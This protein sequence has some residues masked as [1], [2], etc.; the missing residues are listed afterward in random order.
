[1][2]RLK[3][4]I[5][6]FLILAVACND[7]ENAADA[8][9]NFETRE[10]MISAQVNGKLIDLQVEKGEIL[11][12]DMVVGMIDTLQYAL[13]LQR[14]LAQKQ[15]VSSRI[16]DIR[17]N[18]S[19]MEAQKSNLER[20]INR[21]RNLL[22]DKAATQQ[23]L[24]DLEGKL[25]VTDKQIQ[26]AQTSMQNIHHELQAMDSQIAI[27]AEQLS[28]CTIINPLQGTVLEKYAETFELIMPG[29]PLYKIADLS[30]MDLKVYVSGGMLP[31]IALGQNVRV[32]IDQDADTNREIQGTVNWI[33]SRAEFTPKTIQT[34]E[35]RINQV[36]AVKISVPNDGAIKIGMP[37]EVIF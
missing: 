15:A 24:D 11:E 6:L 36:Y 8:W 35:E 1:M 4:F 32:F 5:P 27:A 29:K 22:A 12:K 9:G 19:V 37:G 13:G 17:A 21:T 33:S 14:L 25:L 28:Q 7:T 26:A 31:H 30:V 2:N 10:T 16:N 18:V 34:K 3:I 20:E 23:Q